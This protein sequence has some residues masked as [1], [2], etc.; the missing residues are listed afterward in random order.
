[1]VEGA[2]APAQEDV[3]TKFK[4]TEEK[5]DELREAF[6][7]FD[8]VRRPVFA[9]TQSFMQPRSYGFSAYGPVRRANLRVISSPQD[10]DGHVSPKE[11]Q[12]VLMSLGQSPSEEVTRLRARAIACASVTPR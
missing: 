11:L 2:P 4:L 1:M 5:I 8:K 3:A 7:L 6:G 9:T 12:V 10:G